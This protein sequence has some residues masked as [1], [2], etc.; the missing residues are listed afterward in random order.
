[1]KSILCYIFIIVLL[2]SCKNKSEGIYP[3]SG[4]LTESVYATVTIKPDSLYEVYAAVAGILQQNL[5][6]EG[7]TVTKGQPLFQIVNNTPVLQVENAKLNLEL[8]RKNLQGE[9]NVLDELENQIRTAELQFHN[10]SINFY[11]Q[12]SLWEKNIGSKNAYDQKQLAF[13]LSA[14]R[15]SL[16]LQQYQ[17]TK[18][19][20]ITHLEQARNNYETSR[21]SK[22]EYTVTSRLN[23]R[24]YAV[25]KEPGELI[26]QQHALGNVGSAGNFIIEMMVDEKDIVRLDTG[27]EVV[28]VL[29]A[30]GSATFTATIS[31]ILPEKNERNQSF[32]V[33]ALFTNVPPRLYAGLAGEANIIISRKTQTLSIPRSYLVNDSLVRT[34]EGMQK[35]ETGMESLDRIEILSGI[36]ASTRILKPQS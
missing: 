23:G 12:K 1:M 29:D 20:L 28:L 7:D 21:I 33:E 36:E 24:V 17:R 32:T 26:T 2:F 35:V 31:R 3:D 22:D 8:A 16:L 10:D 15:L 19:E 30:Y 6:K 11:R 13:E 14:N 27:Q 25:Y 9:N 4:P 18:R 5:V 34:P